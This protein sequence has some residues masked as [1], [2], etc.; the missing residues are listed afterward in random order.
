MLGDDATLIFMEL[1]KKLLEIIKTIGDG[2]GGK[3]KEANEKKPKIKIG[4]MS[5]KDYKNLLQ[6][7]QKLN[8]ITLDKRNLESFEKSVKSLGGSIFV[9]KN[10]DTNNA[11]VAFPAAQTDLINTALKHTIGEVMK[12]DPEK[13]QVKNGSKLNRR[14]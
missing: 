11:V 4:S 9:T 1:L 3:P 6:D 2:H 10:K 12:S 7:G 8:Y 13:I 14:I 5:K